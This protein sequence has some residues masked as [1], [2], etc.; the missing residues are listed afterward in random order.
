MKRR[1]ALKLARELESGKWKKGKG[2]LGRGE[3]VRCCLGV[4][5]EIAPKAL[6]RAE[7]RDGLPSNS[8]LD[9]AG[10][11]ESEAGTLAY[12]NDHAKGW[13]KIIENLRETP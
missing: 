12:A 4:L 2:Q 10:L 6:D 7:L 3:Y 13:A 9:W 8:V 5:Q 11:Q 1:I